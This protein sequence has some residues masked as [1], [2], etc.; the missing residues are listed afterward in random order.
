MSSWIVRRATPHDWPN[1]AALLETADLPL[2]G[3]EAHL[4]DFFLAF[5]D[6]VLIGSAGLECYGDIALLRSV[7]VAFPERGQNLGQALVQQVLAY[8]ASLKVRQ[9]VLL[10]TTAADFFLRFGFQPISRAEFPRASQ[11]SVEFREACTASATA[12]SL[13]FEM[14]QR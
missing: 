10:T 7:A 13:A 3:A 6:D 12:M 14:E 8:A 5:L 1:L 2:A 11:A 4:S 9:V